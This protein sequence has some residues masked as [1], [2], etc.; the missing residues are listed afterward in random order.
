[1]LNIRVIIIK[2]NLEYLARI[3]VLEK[4][5]IKKEGNNS[6]EKDGVRL[7]GIFFIYLAKGPDPEHVPS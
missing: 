7:Q 6:E 2:I 3:T 4:N 1:M 5:K